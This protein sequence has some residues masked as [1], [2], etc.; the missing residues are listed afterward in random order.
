M[1]A[2]AAPRSTARS[3]SCRACA[4]VAMSDWWASRMLVSVKA[5]APVEQPAREARRPAVR[6][7]VP[8]AGSGSA[9]AAGTEGGPGAAALPVLLLTMM[10]PMKLTS[11]QWSRARPVQER[12]SPR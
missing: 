1:A 6:P 3:P 9:T 4:G 12:R 8:G 10:S 7:A 5:P 2:A 11:G